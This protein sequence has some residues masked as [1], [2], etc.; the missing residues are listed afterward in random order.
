MRY[1][2]GLFVAAALLFTLSL[3][4]ACAQATKVKGRVVDAVTGEG[5]P[6]AGV[7]FMDTTQGVSADK[8]GYFSLETRIDTLSRLSARN[9]GYREQ[10]LE[11]QPRR[12]NEVT[13]RLIPVSA[14]L[15]AAFV[16]PGDPYMK[17]ILRKIDEA[18]EKNDPEKRPQ[19]DC[20]VYARTELD[21]SN[22][23]SAF[24]E[25]ILPE[26]L[27]FVY[28]Y[29]DTSLVTGQPYLPV[30]LSE[31]T[32]RFYHS[33]EPPRKK[34]VMIASRISGIEKVKTLSQFT[35]NMYLKTNFY[36]NFIN[37]YKVD[38]P[39]PL[40]ENGMSFYDY[41]LVDSLKI[42]GRKTYRIRFSPTKWVSSPALDGEMSIDASDFALR[43][44]HCRLMNGT[45]VNW[46]KSLSMDVENQ[47]LEDSTWFYKQD[48]IYIDMALP[49]KDSSKMVSFVASRQIDYSDPS[50]E[51]KGMIDLLTN[52]TPVLV[53][54]DAGN[55]DE[56]FWEEVR[57]YPLSE[58]EQGIYSMVDTIKT[59][60]L[61]RGAETLVNTAAKGFLNFK[62]L[63]IGPYYSLYS[64][65]ALEGPRVQLGVKTTKN[66][67]RKFRFMGYMAYGF[68][69]DALKGGGVF[70][71]QF[72]NQPTRKLALSY[73]HDVLQLGAG[74]FGFGNGDL[75]TSILTKRGG[76]KLSMIDDYSISYEYEW[77]QDV[78]M[79]VALES[80]RI[81]SNE[82]VPM[83]HRD[84][85]L[86][87]SVGYNQAHL[88]LRLSKDQIVTRGLFEKSYVYTKYPVVTFD[89]A[90]SMKGIGQNDYNFLRPEVRIQYKWMTPPLGES[91]I[92]FRAGTIV[93]EVPYPMLKIHEGN[94]T[95]S[96]HRHAFA[97]MNYYEF[98]SDT[99]ASIFWEHNFKGFFL[100][101]IPLIKKLKLREIAI[102]RAAYG[103]VRDENNGIPGDRGFGSEMLFP[104]GMKKLDTPYV[105]MGFGISN[106]L[107]FVRVDCIWRMTHRD[108]MIDGVKV[109]HDNRF[110][111]NVGFEFKF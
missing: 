83:V 21:L 70:E 75:M 36:S 29:I 50:F 74:S 73:K 79:T 58:K 94:G 64:F 82:F 105:E 45:N 111:V 99:W 46:V 63:G 44:V 17:Y 25:K 30:M 78:N 28:E 101:K 57:P 62:Y 86:Y 16:K 93:G 108:D 48:R 65:N 42:D 92:D 32:S 109:P 91:D 110:V 88:R 69:D 3:Q 61:Y 76:R 95:Y 35:G 103:T 5:I 56:S 38:I 84:G 107:R 6:F 13:F 96:L 7:Y 2:T 104:A 67:S 43:E 55:N 52:E 37:I 12:F 49:L 15:S 40:H 81:F 31:S 19:Y 97:C 77:T 4:D 100:G 10:E 24:I 51:D 80:R 68:K 53:K 66:V 14:E 33:S 102:L 9:L 1:I 85:S 23:R 98:A 87:N 59:L 60:R 8:D 27:K 41:Y 106:I 72:N 22:P 71:Y 11:V 90:A 54:K 89:I 18:R 26:S 34:E 47:M 39:S 20:E